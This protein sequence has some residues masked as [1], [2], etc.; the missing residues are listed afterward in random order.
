M[1]LWPIRARILFELFYKRPLSIEERSNITVVKKKTK[2]K[3]QRYLPLR[4]PTLPLRDNISSRAAIKDLSE[5]PG[6]RI[7]K[8]WSK[9]YVQVKESPAGFPR[10]NP[11]WTMLASDI[12]GNILRHPTQCNW[13]C[14]TSKQPKIQTLKTCL[15]SWV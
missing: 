3:K 9:K 12:A 11:D 6:I 5:V 13:V 2:K 4:T 15:T 7:C 8:L 10:Q 14:L 1:V